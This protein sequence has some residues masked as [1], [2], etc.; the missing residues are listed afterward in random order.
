MPRVGLEQPEQQLIKL[1]D[2]HPMLFTF[3]GWD[4]G[5]T[6]RTHVNCRHDELDAPVIHLIADGMVDLNR[7]PITIDGNRVQVA[8]ADSVPHAF[9]L[10]TPVEN[11]VTLNIRVDGS[12]ATFSMTGM[13]DR[14]TRVNMHVTIPV[15]TPR[16]RFQS[17]PSAEELMQYQFMQEKQRMNLQGMY[18]EQ[19]GESVRRAQMQYMPMGSWGRGLGSGFGSLGAALSGQ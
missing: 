1:Y 8:I 13:A 6:M 7:T 14:L 3:N 10:G 15:S 2:K 5:W 9:T 12:I 4:G 18:Y 16:Y 11:S 17:I 19:Q